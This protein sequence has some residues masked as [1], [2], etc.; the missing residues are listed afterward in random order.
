[1]FYIVCGEKKPNWPWNLIEHPSQ[2]L[3][4]I[5]I[6][7]ALLWKEKKKELCPRANSTFYRQIPNS[8]MHIFVALT[9]FSVPVEGRPKH[10]QI[11]VI[12]FSHLECPRPSG[13][14]Y[15]LISWAADG[16]LSVSS[17][18]TSW[19]GCWWTWQR[20]GEPLAVWGAGGAMRTTPPRPGVL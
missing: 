20:R 19:W 2:L 18:P 8:S 13:R 11:P 5:G 9:S 15:E 6:P 7:T 1:M 16:W 12:A 4:F 14:L 10:S 3:T 17:F